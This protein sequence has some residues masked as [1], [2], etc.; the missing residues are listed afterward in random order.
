MFSLSYFSPF[1]LLSP[2]LFF[3]LSLSFVSSF[4]SYF[5]IV[6]LSPHTLSLFVFLY[7]LLLS[8]HFS[9]ALLLSHFVFFSFFCFS[10]TLIFLFL[11]FFFSLFSFL[12]PSILVFFFLSLC[13]SLFLSIFLF[14]YL[15][16]CVN[17]YMRAPACLRR[18][19]MEGVLDICLIGRSL[20]IVSHLPCDWE[21][22]QGKKLG[23]C[24]MD[25][26]SK[27]EKERMENATAIISDRKESSWRTHQN[28]QAVFTR[29]DCYA[30]PDHL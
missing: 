12:S 9:F 10:L 21:K 23:W 27:K 3:S 16:L 13:S 14:R 11:S 24:N 6:S 26:D 19:V 29:Q 4:F 2:S 25:L 7:F 17:M 28:M 30:R 8:L 1:L 22:R 20:Q 5:F 15:Y 18:T